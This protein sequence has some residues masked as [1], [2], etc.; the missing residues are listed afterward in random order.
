MPNT[1]PKPA[2]MPPPPPPPRGVQKPCVFERSYYYTYT[3]KCARGCHTV[4]H[5]L[6][7]Q[8]FKPRDVPEEGFGYETSTELA[9]RLAFAE[10]E[11]HQQKKMRDKLF[12]M[13][14]AAIDVPSS[15]QMSTRFKAAEEGLVALKSGRDEERATS[16]Q[17]ARSLERY[18]AGDPCRKSY[19][20]A[21]AIVE[22]TH[23]DLRKY[24]RLV[25]PDGKLKNTVESTVLHM[26]SQAI[27]PIVKASSFP[28][29]LNSR[30]EE[31]KMAQTARAQ[32]KPES[33]P[34]GAGI[35]GPRQDR[36]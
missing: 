17:L 5:T 15:E 1:R 4:Q 9:T 35:S 27:N 24:A 25:H 22:G 12:A 30:T 7:L 19:L 14:D 10:R 33:P 26:L 34:D 6:N 20:K 21:R 2:P 29:S 36:V 28:E 8:N 11:V 23:R 13:I 32:G 3:Q 31:Q 18:R 16:A